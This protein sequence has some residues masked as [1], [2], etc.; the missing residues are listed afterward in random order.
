MKEN[1]GE[2][3]LIKIHC[4][5]NENSLYNKYMLIKIKKRKQ[6]TNAG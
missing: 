6:T 3:N 1:D 4:K 2:V 5:H